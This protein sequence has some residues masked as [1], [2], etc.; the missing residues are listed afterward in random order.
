M[1]YAVYVHL[2]KDQAYSKETNPSSRNRG[3]Y[4]RTITEKKSQVMGIRR[5]DTKIN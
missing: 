1:L 5:L 2:A 3:C 4:I